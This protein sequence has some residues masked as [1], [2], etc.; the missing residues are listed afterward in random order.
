MI[1][2]ARL[3]AQLAADIQRDGIDYRE[4]QQLLQHLHQ[5]LLAQRAEDIAAANGRIQA[6]LATLNQRARLRAR[7]LVALGTG[8]DGEAVRR[9]LGE[10]AAPL[11]TGLAQA[12]ATLELD[13]LACR[14]LN[15]R[16]GEV[17]RLHRELF[18]ELLGRSSATSIYSD[19][20]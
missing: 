18:Q 4:L 12:W 10:F 20:L 15:E 3:L 11:G 6:V 16:N 19:P 9:L 7:L 14:R 17:L 5:Q 1:P 2:R 8:T 13:V